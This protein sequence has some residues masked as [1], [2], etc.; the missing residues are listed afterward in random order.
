MLKQLAS[1]HILPLSTHLYRANMANLY[2]HPCDS[3]A[4]V[5]D[6]LAGCTLRHKNQPLYPITRAFEVI[7]D[8][9]SKEA[10]TRW[11]NLKP[12][13][14]TVVTQKV[15]RSVCCDEDSMLRILKAAKECPKKTQA[16]I[17]RGIAE[18]T[19]KVREVVLHAEGGHQIA[20]EVCSLHCLIC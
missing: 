6:P 20:I 11:T 7:E 17:F 3:R 2:G 4:P 13:L 12:K 8:L 15:G 5:V 9:T 18:D 1:G 10:S 16:L 19:T 14:P